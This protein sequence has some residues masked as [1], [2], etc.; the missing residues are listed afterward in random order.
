MNNFSRALLFSAFALIVSGCSEKGE[1]TSD[2]QVAEM[3]QAVAAEQSVGVENEDFLLFVD[4][5]A[6]MSLLQ[7]PLTATSLGV[8]DDFVGE[9]FN[10][11]LGDFSQAGL[12]RL[13]RE[14][15][16]L[17][18]QMAQFDPNELSGTA[19]TTYQVVQHALTVTGQLKP[20]T[21][22]TF[23]PISYFS[24]FPV[25]QIS[26]PHIDI[27]RSL[28]SEHPLTSEEDARDYIARLN[29]IKPAFADLS[30]VVLNDINRGLTPPKFAVEGAIGFISQVLESPAGESSLTTTFTQRLKATSDLDDTT[31]AALTAEVTM[32]V[33]ESVYP[34]Y[35][36]L[37][38]TLESIL[39][40]ASENA[41]VWDLK[42]GDTIYQLALENFGASGKSAEEIHQLGLSE[43]A[44]IQKEMAVILDAQGMDSSDVIAT[45]NKL[46]EDPKYLF[47]NTDAGRQK[48]LD[49][50][51][52]QMKTVTEMLPMILKTLPK[53]AVEVRRIAPYEQDGAP[54]GYYT[55]PTLDGSRP[56]IYWINLKETSDW[57]KFTL[58]TLTYHEASPG[59]HLQV[60]IAQEI[61]DMPMLRNM[62][63]FSAY[64][65]GWALYAE[66]LAKEM[67]LYK[68]DPLGDLGRLQSEL[69]RAARLVTD[70][71]IH[72][73]HWSRDQ[74]VDYM[75]ETIG[76]SRAAIER[77]VERYSVWPGQACSYKLGQMKILEL[78]DLAKDTLGDKFD[79]A[80]FNDQVLIY[81]S[82]SLSVL[83]A[84]IHTWLASKGVDL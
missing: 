37:K 6:Q 49:Y 27:L 33:E 7:S 62:I 75:Y 16:E 32:A 34:G 29:Q 44:R 5:V 53:A 25:T 63:W 24:L 82:I 40:Q 67:G 47:A 73:K 68:D 41:G 70:T 1:V 64:G 74:A 58:P 60:A 35:T 31:I 57:P 78:R 18:A 79:L 42:D 14:H 84:K 61:P 17:L 39:P 3:E 23:Q 12:E 11:K 43:V 71:G 8:S 72:Y 9:H 21:N 26:G 52:G 36:Q 69:F 15:D 30:E 51:N 54:G 50:L 48:L 55:N 80:E 81:G 46:S 4:R 59:H 56:G 45:F 66:R 83:E 28:Q 10:D 65:E 19:L 38:T 22:G 13:K 2:T 20:Y 77:E 76:G